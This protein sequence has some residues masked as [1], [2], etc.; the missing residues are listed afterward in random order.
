[1]KH[2]LLLLAG[3]AL[4]PAAN[5]CSTV[6]NISLETFGEGVTIELRSGV[7]GKSKVIATRQSH[8]G[9]VDFE[10]LC[11]GKYFLA[12]GNEEQVSVTPVRTF[13]NNASYAS[14]IVVQTGAGNVE[15]RSR[16]SL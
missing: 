10:N 14:S 2:A 8:G 15:T 11:A 16:S 5:A 12:I 7:P 13:E 9:Q 1:M 6:W 4:M 3:L